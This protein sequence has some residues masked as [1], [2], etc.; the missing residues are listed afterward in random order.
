MTQQSWGAGGITAGVPGLADI[1]Q[2]DLSEDYGH[3]AA[4]SEP[5]P[6]V[7]TPVLAR[8]ARSAPPLI[9]LT[10]LTEETEADLRSTSYAHGQTGT[11]FLSTAGQG[12]RFNSFAVPAGPRNTCQHPF[13]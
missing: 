11:G 1:L 2:E 8:P 7:L 4:Q 12:E 9:A 10:P 5:T 13:A 3:R 6:P